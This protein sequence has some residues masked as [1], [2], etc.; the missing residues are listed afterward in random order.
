MS[1]TG[2][3]SAE[4][5]ITPQSIGRSVSQDVEIYHKFLEAVKYS[6][7]V[8]TRLADIDFFPGALDLARKVVSD[9]FTKQVL[10]RITDKA[11]TSESSY[12]ILKELDGQY[13]EDHGTTHISVLDAE[14]NAVSITTTVNMM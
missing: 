3:L 12:Q 13:T 11:G 1:C 10:S 6:Y 2:L 7:S 9:E 5:N 8:R 4:L 14:G